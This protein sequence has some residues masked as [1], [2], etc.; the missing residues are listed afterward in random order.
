MATRP[1]TALVVACVESKSHHATVSVA[2]TLDQAA[3]TAKRL[4]T[5]TRKLDSSKTRFPLLSLYKGVAWSSVRELHET[6]GS[7]VDVWVAS[8]GLGLMPI[9]ESGPAY[10]ATFA[11]RHADSIGTSKTDLSTWWSGLGSW[12]PVWLK[13]A[14]PRQIA[15]LSRRYD[16]IL[17]ALP[18]PYLAA[19]S[20]DVGNRPEK[21]L[22]CGL[23]SIRPLPE[24]VQSVTIPAGIRQVVGGTLTS[25]LNRTI[26]EALANVGKRGHARSLSAEVRRMA[27]RAP[28]LVIPKRSPTSSEW[29][30]GFISAGLAEGTDSSATAALARLRRSDYACEETR[31]R[32]LYREVFHSMQS[33]SAPSR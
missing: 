2:E 13:R 30:R 25:A 10:G 24:L 33:G 7:K 12:Q 1:R 29:I 16:E 6:Y 21:I 27:E 17:V 18:A 31:F 14:G 4:Q 26:V 11:P 9:G 20:E 8:A 15:D 19:V 23:G 22:V 28:P 5:W 3:T 32:D